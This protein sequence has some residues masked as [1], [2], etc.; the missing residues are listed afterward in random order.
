MLLIGHYSLLTTLNE[1]F[2]E[3]NGAAETALDAEALHYC[4]QRGLKLIITAG[5]YTQKGLQNEVAGSVKNT[6]S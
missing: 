2:T 1:G 5:N 4:L 3:R 6:F